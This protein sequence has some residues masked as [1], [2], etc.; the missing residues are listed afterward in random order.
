[1]DYSLNWYSHG[2]FFHL[3]PCSPFFLLCSNSL[4]AG[5]AREKG[6]IDQTRH[7]RPSSLK[8]ASDVAEYHA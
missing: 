1:G 3:R 8:I 6:D 4:L 7:F 2:I 5:M